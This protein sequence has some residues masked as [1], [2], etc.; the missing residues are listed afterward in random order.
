MNF[1]SPF[2]AKGSGRQTPVFIVPEADV[3]SPFPDCTLCTWVAVK[4]HG[5]RLKYTSAACHVHDR[6][7]KIPA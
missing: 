5:M 7:P 4:G 3:Y 2:V 6:L 1:I